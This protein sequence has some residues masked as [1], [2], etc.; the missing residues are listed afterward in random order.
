LFSKSRLA[1][2]L[3][4]PDIR[5]AL[6]FLAAFFVVAFLA[7][8]LAPP[9]VRQGLTDAFRIATEPY[10]DQSGGVVF[11]FI[12]LNN[13][14]A[15]ILMLLL[16]MVF[17]VLPVVGVVSN[18]LL[19]GVLWRQAAKIAGYGQAALSILPH[20][21]FEIPAL[22]LAASYGLWLGMAAIQRARGLR[23]RD[24]RG[25]VKHALRRDAEIILP[26]LVIA[27]V[28]ETALVVM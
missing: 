10:T 27:A 22:L 18:G 14:I 21:I 1:S 20:G 15:T 5:P 2:F 25:Q 6:F 7:G 9:S 26:L 23:D 8:M 11:L 19:L 3:P 16:G 17:G 24:I 12:L 4:E 28:I 13:V